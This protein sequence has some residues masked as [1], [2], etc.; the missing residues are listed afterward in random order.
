VKK[1]LF[2]IHEQGVVRRPADSLFLGQEP[3][4][5]TGLKPTGYQQIFAQPNYLKTGW[6]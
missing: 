3:V 4:E 1:R 6:L 5:K 2:H